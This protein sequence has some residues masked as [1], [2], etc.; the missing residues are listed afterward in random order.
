MVNPDNRAGARHRNTYVT[1]QEL[2]QQLQ[3]W[4]AE[5]PDVIH[6][7]SLASSREGRD[8]WLVV[9]GE[10]PERERPSVWVDG[11]MHAGELAGCAVTLA[12]IEDLISLHMHPDQP[13]HGLSRE[14]CAQLRKLRFYCVPRIS[15]DGAELVVSGAGQVRSSPYNNRRPSH[16]PRWRITD[17]N[18]DGL[19]L[20]M[21]KQDPTG[22]FCVSTI[23]PGL[24]VPRG[25]GDPGPFYKVYPEG[26]IDGF[27]GHTIPTPGGPEDGG[28]DYNRN[29]PWS[30]APEPRQAGAGAYPGSEPEV[31]SVIDYTSK[32][33]SVFAWINYH[34]FGGVVI[35][36]LGHAHDTEMATHD[37]MMFREVE[38]IASRHTG[39]P[40]VCGYKEFTYVPGK[41]LHGDAVDYAYHQRGC[42]AVAIELWDVFE[43]AGIG[44]RERF[45]DRYASMTRA[46][47]EAIALWD[48]REN[49]GRC[50]RPW[51][52]FDHPQL[53]PVEVGGVDPRF[54]LWNPPED[55]LAEVCRQQSAFVLHVAAMAP[56][57]VL[58]N[59]TIEELGDNRFALS[60]DV[61]NHG[62]LPTYGLES[63]RELPWNEGL[64]AWCRPLAD[65]KVVAPDST[66]TEVGHL[67][68]WGRGPFG[69]NACLYYQRSRGSTG[70]KHLRFVV[71]GHGEVEVEVAGPRVGRIRHRF[72]LPQ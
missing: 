62:Y 6:L 19:A 44:P 66:Y 22:E 32:L 45:V 61:E 10:E 21:R 4:A 42:L 49:R 48:Q 26:V 14:L 54:G 64:T 68:G 33:P 51:V 8:V 24:L 17:V 7:Q 56:R 52:A 40:T 70:R 59:P 31:A 60:L 23:V 47:L 43:R 9:V 25:L 16:R 35:R 5:Y 50:V 39:Y 2:T 27:D 41:P 53:G 18:G 46:E 28:V 69:D 58:A 37:Y 20:V 30:W 3:A 12:V 15:P 34:T 67:D 65:A 36:P 11:N 72:E 38:D 29:F 57:V 71:R 63:A 55:K 13:L 1:H